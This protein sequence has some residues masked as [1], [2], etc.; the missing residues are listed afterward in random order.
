MHL[1]YPAEHKAEI[2]KLKQIRAISSHNPCPFPSPCH[3]SF[4]QRFAFNHLK[5]HP[6]G[7]R[8]LC[9]PLNVIFFSPKNILSTAF[10]GLKCEKNMC[11]IPSHSNTGVLGFS[12]RFLTRNETW[13]SFPSISSKTANNLIFKCKACSEK[14]S[15]DVIHLQSRRLH[16]LIWGQDLFQIFAP[17]QFRPF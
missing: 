9:L 13:N 3:I 12:G 14:V 6:W 17:T 5:I 2:Q 16:Q 8:F 11:L 1:H 7:F 10:F 4:Q 15:G